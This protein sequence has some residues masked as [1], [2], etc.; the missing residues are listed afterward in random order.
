M[1]QS[2][3]R[4]KDP[5]RLTFRLQMELHEQ[6][7]DHNANEGKILLLT[8]RS[9]PLWELYVEKNDKRDP[10]LNSYLL[11]CSRE[12]SHHPKPGQPSS[13]QVVNF[14]HLIA[15]TRSYQDFIQGN[16]WI[17]NLDIYSFCNPPISWRCMCWPEC[18]ALFT[19]W[20]LLH[21]W[22]CLQDDACMIFGFVYKMTLAWYLGLFTRWRIVPIHD[23]SPNKCFLWYHHCVVAR[24][25]SWKKNPISHSNKPL[26]LMYFNEI[27]E[28][29]IFLTV[30]R[31][32]DRITHFHH[33][34]PK[35]KELPI[36]NPLDIHTFHGININ[37]LIEP[38]H[39]SIS[40][41]LSHRI[42][43]IH[44]QKAHPKAC[45]VGSLDLVHE[46]TQFS[47]SGDH[48]RNVHSAENL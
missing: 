2:I 14:L 39:Q 36:R 44:I 28:N 16:A 1:Q 38:L 3:L 22:L 23:S 29:H 47:G 18:L 46:I 27:M 4:S 42:P 24:G 35:I 33:I 9:S 5:V 32:W 25:H 10:C 43:C 20:H 31:K 41:T 21:I 17:Q 6:N 30:S 37:L 13:C 12:I 26:L 11:A 7:D 45:G 34:L 8:R 19:R 15:L 48:Q 40:E